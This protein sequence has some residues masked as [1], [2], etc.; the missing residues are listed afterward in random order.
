MISEE[1][2]KDGLQFS[3]PSESRGALAMQARIHQRMFGLDE[4]L[5][6]VAHYEIQRRIGAG[7]MGVVYA[8]RDTALQRD[9]ALKLLRRRPL[10]DEQRTCLL[11]EARALAKISHPNVVSVYEVG[12]HED[13]IFIAMELVEGET[14]MSWQGRERRSLNQ[15]LAMYRQAGAGLVA[16]HDAGVIH[17]DFKPGNAIVGRDGRLRVVDFG[18]AWAAPLDATTSAAGPHG[19]VGTPGYIAPELGRGEPATPASDQFSFCVALAR[20][21]APTEPSVTAASDAAVDELPIVMRGPGW[22]R[23]VLRRGLADQPQLR[24]PSM[25]ELV[26]RLDR[27]RLRRRA[28]AVTLLGVGL[29][30]GAALAGPERLASCEQRAADFDAVWTEARQREL[31]THIE[32]VGAPYADA[33]VEQLERARQT[34]R[35]AWLSAHARVCT[36][37]RGASRQLPLSRELG[38]ACLERK[39]LAVDELLLNLAV[40]TPHTLERLEHQLAELRDPHACEAIESLTARPLG[41]IWAEPTLARELDQARFALAALDF[42]SARERAHTAIGLANGLGHE[43][44]LAEAFELYGR[45]LG[46]GDNFFEAEEALVTA[47]RLAATAGDVGRQVQIRQGLAKLSIEQLEDSSR[48]QRSLDLAGALLEH[49]DDPVLQAEQLVARASLA[50]HAQDHERAVTLLEQAVTSLAAVLGGAH[51]RVESF[52]LRRANALADAGQT[53]RAIEIYRQLLEVR[54][55]RL[56][57]GHPALAAVEFDLGL[58]LLGP[59]PDAALGHFERSL[60][61]EQRAFGPDSL[62]VASTSTWLAELYWRRG[63]LEAAER[64]AARAWPIQ[65]E[66][67]PPD[68]SDRANAL[69]ILA[70]VQLER[71]AYADALASF[72]RVPTPRNPDEAAALDLNRAWLLCRLERC[73]AAQALLTTALASDVTQI[74]LAA[75]VG[76]ADVHLQSGAVELG[77]AQLEALLLELEGLPAPEAEVNAASAAEAR[78]LLARALAG[79]EAAGDSAR[80]REL[81]ASALE[82]YRVAGWPART[83]FELE[84]LIA[85]GHTE[86]ES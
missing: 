9:V 19:A 54:R 44:A 73:D 77:V 22:L 51:P 56:G 36:P 20:A 5:E 63:D 85:C 53:A 32:R 64:A 50:T 47:A 35:A 40:A 24:W 13:E 43:L 62:R 82:V 39:L 12:E 15:L 72:E 31:V 46:G 1:Q 6:T 80:V 28:G 52:E 69:E 18:L 79:R 16:A 23:R 78:W 21:L 17:R 48:A 26:T 33:A 34:H 65:F 68:A 41:G 45:A 57:A 71:G 30:A 4:P 75:R 58:A 83:I 55:A 81:A 76:L 60:E 37:N 59:E 10:S 38:L 3:P 84:Q 11:E 66:R 86:C 42:D 74:E 61:I 14:L 2:G 7:A 70:W 25:A 8:A 67:L 29:V 49:H 27:G